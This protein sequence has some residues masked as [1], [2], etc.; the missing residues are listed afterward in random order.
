MGEAQP[1]QAHILRPMSL[2]YIIYIS[3]IVIRN[4]D[5]E[6]A[7]RICPNNSDTPEALLGGGPNV[8][9]TIRPH[10]HSVQRALTIHIQCPKKNTNQ[11]YPKPGRIA[12]ARPRSVI[13]TLMFLAA[14]APQSPRQTET[15]YAPYT[16]PPL[17]EPSSLATRS[18]R[19]T[20]RS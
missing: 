1:P 7:R 18:R 11:Q 2:V 5:R 6:P 17:P 3:I 15:C 4:L 13:M 9:K 19:G 12:H 16:S 8:S 14:K 20:R 10:A